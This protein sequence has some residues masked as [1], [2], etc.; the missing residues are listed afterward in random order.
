[1][2][3]PAGANVPVGP[4]TPN[5][6]RPPA[7]NPQEEELVRRLIERFVSMG[8]IGSAGRP[9]TATQFPPQQQ[10]ASDMRDDA[11]LSADGD[12]WSATDWG[13]PW[14]MGQSLEAL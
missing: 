4:E 5:E 3:L 2:S 14:W 12:H 10:Q 6:Q 13:Q 1:M 8:V 11:T 9:S 7:D